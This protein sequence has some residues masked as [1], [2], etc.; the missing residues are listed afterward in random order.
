MKSKR[1]NPL[2]KAIERIKH[3]FLLGEIA[4]NVYFLNINLKENPE[5][6]P[7]NSYFKLVVKGDSHA[8]IFLNTNKK[9][10]EDEWLCVLA[11]ACLVLAFELYK[12]S[13]SILKEKASILYALD[14]VYRILNIKAVPLEW[15]SYFSLVQKI[16]FKNDTYVL[17]VIQESAKEYFKDLFNFYNNDDF[18]IELE[19]IKNNHYFISKKKFADIFADNL[20]QQ[21]QRTIALKANNSF[22][23]DEAKKRDLP[24]NKALRWFVTHY[25]L[26]ASLAS[27]FNVVYDKDVC[28]TLNID[29]G[30][31][32]YEEKTIFINPLAQLNDEGLKFVIAHEILHVALAHSSRRKGRDHLIW[33]LACDFVI[34]HWLVEMRVGQPPESVFL[35]KTLAQLS[36]DEI[37]LL[38]AK[39][40]RLRRKMMTLKNKS[41]GLDYSDKF[42]TNENN[43]YYKK[44]KE[45]CD[46]LDE[47]FFAEF[48]DACKKALLRGMFLHQSIG[49]GDLPASLEE[50][51]KLINQPPVPWQVELAKWFMR[52]FPLEERKR[53]YAKPSRRQSSTPDIPRARYIKPFDENHSRTFGVILDTSASMDRQL[54]GK[55]LG[56]IVS[57]AKNQDV[58]VIRL[59]YCD[60]QTY[61]EGYVP[62]EQLINKVTIKGRGGTVLQKAVTYLENANNFPDTAPIMILSDGYFEEDLKVNREHAIL[63]PNRYIVPSYS[64]RTVFEFK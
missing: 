13:K 58:D 32:S 16:S 11:T 2:D 60:A 6:L 46:I 54:L 50:E 3:H 8:T 9:L 1:E 24:E 59:V 48:E 39:D 47:S 36:A 51:I 57:Y 49:R 62:I 38:I 15:N 14:Y 29:I 31:V 5:K 22:S 7:K 37:Y 52:Q 21:A 44:N 25:P 55:C 30:A 40:V 10:T 53:T 26:L 4:Y 23:E 27:N 64:N 28:R 63:V 20:L 56:A 19:D 43:K 17:K 42:S 18:S 12:T 33:N 34:N 41:A 35:D 61:D 45:N